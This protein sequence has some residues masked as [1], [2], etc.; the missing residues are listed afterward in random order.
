MLGFSPL[1]TAGLLTAAAAGVAAFCYSQGLSSRDSKLGHNFE[2]ALMR[3]REVAVRREV[4][5]WTQVGD[6]RRARVEMIET[7]QRVDQASLEA[8]SKYQA[9]LARERSSAKAALDEAMTNI[10]DLKNA[11]SV[12]AKNWKDGVVPDDITCGVFNGKGCGTPAYPAAG[13]DSGD[14]VAVRD[15]AKPAAAGGNP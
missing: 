14:D 11:T 13:A 8:R 4:N 2:H 3:E 7:F 6:E 5:L 15:G 10:E 9:A 12:M 1:I